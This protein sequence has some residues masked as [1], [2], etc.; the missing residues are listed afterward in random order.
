ME[1]R[2]D[3]APKVLVHHA[4]TITE[5]FQLEWAGLIVMVNILLFTHARCIAVN[6]TTQYKH[7]AT[8]CIMTYVV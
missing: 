2:E 1:A 5:T 8:V 4:C 3:M 7:V 6:I